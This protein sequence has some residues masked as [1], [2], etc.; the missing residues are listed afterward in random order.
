M[1]RSPVCRAD[2]G[3]QSY[4]CRQAEDEDARRHCR[5]C[6]LLSESSHLLFLI[7]K[8]RKARI[9]GVVGAEGSLKLLNN[10]KSEG[11]PP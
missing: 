1:V 2:A 10:R 6:S 7:A 3:Q 4:A 9:D 11:C 5:A 8:G